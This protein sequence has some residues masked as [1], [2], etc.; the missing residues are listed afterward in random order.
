MKNEL[1][2]IEQLDWIIRLNYTG[3]T[4][5]LSKKLNVSKAE[6]NKG[7]EKMKQ[8]NL[9]AVFSIKLQSYIYERH[10]NLSYKLVRQ[11]L[12]LKTKERIIGLQNIKSVDNNLNRKY[13]IL[14]A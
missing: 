6:L 3:N 4:S 2:I 7:L 8:Y 14:K 9:Q 12:Y 13:T 10:T 11:I 1:K 5:Q